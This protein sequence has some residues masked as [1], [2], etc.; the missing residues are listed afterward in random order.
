MKIRYDPQADAMYIHLK[1]AEIVNTDEVE[2]G[3]MEDY[4]EEGN[5]VGIEILDVSKRIEALPLPTAA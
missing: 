1:E 4:D 2:P 5:V 3:I